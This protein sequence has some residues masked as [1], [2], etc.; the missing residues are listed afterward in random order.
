MSTIDRNERIIETAQYTDDYEGGRK[1]KKKNKIARKS[2]RE[3]KRSI[4]R[5]QLQIAIGT[6]LE[7]ETTEVRVRRSRYDD[8]DDDDDD[9]NHS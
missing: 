2:R 5:Y 9:D 8:D 1:K 7:A 3:L 6:I 4:G